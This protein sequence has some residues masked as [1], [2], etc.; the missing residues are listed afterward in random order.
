[1]NPNSSAAFPTNP[2]D[3]PAALERQVARQLA[4]EERRRVE[5]R[6][7]AAEER[8]RPRTCRGPTSVE[9]PN[10]KFD[11]YV[12]ST[13]F[14]ST[15]TCGVGDVEVRDRVERG[16]D[17]VRRPCDQQLVLARERRERHVRESSRAWSSVATSSAG[18]TKFV[19]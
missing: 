11:S 16:L 8:V 15:N 18:G 14:A 1:M 2:N 3:E 7:R 9:K 5:R 6:R 19:R 12:I 17:R 13:I 4:L 10:S